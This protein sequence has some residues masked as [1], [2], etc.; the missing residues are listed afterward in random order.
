MRVLIIEDEKPAARRLERMILECDPSI[1]VVDKIDSVEAAVNWL[2]T[3]SD[4]DLLFMDIQLADGISF[5]IFS[6]VEV[7]A[8]VVFTTAYDQYMLQAFKVNSVDYLL[9]PIDPNELCAALDKFKRLRSG[10]GSDQ[11]LLA[12]KSMMEAMRPQEFKSRFMVKMGQ[13]LVVVPLD[14]VAYF[15]SEDGLA[16][17]VTQSG[18]R[19]AMDQ[20]LDQLKNVLDPAKFF[21]INRK[22]VVCFESINKIH[23]WFNSRLKLELRP[24]PK[25]DV[26]VSRD[27]V[28]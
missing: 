17:L 26:V 27:R 8:P 23:T 16:F 10:E 21:R 9:K 11:Q 28:S 22:L 12:I 19:F 25:G 18:K 14:E 13:Q 1:D 6:K 4:P 20:S 24:S 15:L 7:I 2:T 5:D 3:F